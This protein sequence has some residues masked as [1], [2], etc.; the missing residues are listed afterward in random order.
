VPINYVFHPELPLVVTTGSGSLTEA[1]LLSVYKT[2]LADPRISAGT[3]ELI[4]LRNVERFEVTAK[5]VRE[6]AELETKHED[7]IGPAPVAV[8]VPS[9]H[10]YGM[11]RMYQTFSEMN[12]QSVRVFQ[13]FSGVEDWLGVSVPAD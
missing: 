13:E 12:P 6:L 9:N 5:G 4:D 1:E 2:S 8:L 7:K 10:I 11:V 3:P